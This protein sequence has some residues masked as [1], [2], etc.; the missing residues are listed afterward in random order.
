MRSIRLFLYGIPAALILLVVAAFVNASFLSV[1]KKNEMSIGTIGEPSTLNPIQ[2]ADSASGQVAGLMFNG[3]LK[4]NQDLEVVGDLATAWDLS[5]ET[6]FQF[7]SEEE[8]AKALSFLNEHQ[9]SNSAS[10]TTIAGNGKNLT[11]T[12]SQ[13]GLTD[14][15][16]IAHILSEAG[17][18]PLPFPPL[19]KGSKDRQFK[20]EPIIRF[21]LRKDVHWHDGAPFTSADVAFTYHAIMDARVASPSSSDFELVSALETPNPYSVVVRY[22][23]PFSPP[24]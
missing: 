22:K 24:Y 18:H 14:S 11:L 6:T 12:L 23:K 4:Y 13:P 17:L 8:A 2:Q 19:D 20:A 21:T 16:N 9:S 10:I 15:E 5:Q 1:A 7:G 3:L